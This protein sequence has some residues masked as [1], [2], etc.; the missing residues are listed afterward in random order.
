MKAIAIVYTHTLVEGNSMDLIDDILGTSKNIA[1]VGI[2][3]KPNRESYR[4]ASYLKRVGYRIIPV[5]PSIEEVL[6][7]VCYPTLRSITETVDIVDIFRRLDQI[8]YVVEEAIEISARYIW[9]QDGLIDHVAAEMASIA[10]IPTI[11]DNC[12]MRENRYIS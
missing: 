10:S 11:M 2:S 6:G 9:M 4:V 1:V 12:I 7:E 5:N 3:D 8:R